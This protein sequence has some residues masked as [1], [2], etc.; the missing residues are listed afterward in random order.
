LMLNY[1]AHADNV[2]AGHIIEQV[3]KAVRAA[4]D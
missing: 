3:V 2:D 4:R 1:A